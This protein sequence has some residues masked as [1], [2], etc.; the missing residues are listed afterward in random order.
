MVGPS[1][2]GIHGYGAGMPS[3][4][5]L[6]TAN[7]IH[8]GLLKLSGGRVGSRLS[9]MP[10]LALTTTGRKSGK[11]RT[12]MLTSP[13][14]DD[15]K[16]V[17]VASRGGDDRHPDWYLNLVAD[18][19]VEVQV[20]GEPARPMTARIATAEERAEMWPRVT[21]VHDGYAGYQARTDREI[22]LVILEP[23]A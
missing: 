7:V 16:L 13:V 8:R 21:A 1:A 14:S 17:V 6:R 11:P 5:F 10:V 4:L 23:R 19:Q 9:D 3:D 18:P 15:G 20:V 2:A 12:V 22:P